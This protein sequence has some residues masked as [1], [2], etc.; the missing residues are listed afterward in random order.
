MRAF[1]Q[2]LRFPGFSKLNL[3]LSTSFPRFSVPLPLPLGSDGGRNQLLSVAPQH[4]PDL[5]L[6]HHAAQGQQQDVA[7]NH[8]GRKYWGDSCWSPWVSQHPETPSRSLN[9]ESEP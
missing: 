2:G 5:H 7:G 3:L 9:P 4:R 8:S 6:R 1:E